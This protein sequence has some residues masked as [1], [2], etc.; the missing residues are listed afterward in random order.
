MTLGPHDFSAILVEVGNTH[1]L[2]HYQARPVY[3]FA[4][5]ANRSLAT[6]IGPDVKAMHK[7]SGQA[8][9]KTAPVEDKSAVAQAFAGVSVPLPSGP[10]M[11]RWA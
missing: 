10:A 4:A 11:T 3:C 1:L 2:Q 7:I 5:A 6:D 9:H 8:A